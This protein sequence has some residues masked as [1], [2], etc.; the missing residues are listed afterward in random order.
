V[1]ENIDKDDLASTL[2]ENSDLH[3]YVSRELSENYRFTE[4]VAEDINIPMVAREVDLDN[5]ARSVIEF[6]KFIAAVRDALPRV[7]E[8]VEE[9]PVA[10]TSVEVPASLTERLLEMAVTRLL[11]MAD[12]AARDG[13]V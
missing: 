7:E 12:E 4:R 1:A 9:P 13:K 6:P 2:A 10:P 11:T 5:L 8:R 3:D